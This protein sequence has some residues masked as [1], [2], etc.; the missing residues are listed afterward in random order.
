MESLDREQALEVLETAPV[1]HL[2]MIHEGE[3]YVTPM[4]FVVS[5]GRVLFRTMAG[6]KL[7][8]LRENPVVCIEISR[9]DEETGEWKS[10]IVKG[11]AEEVEEDELKQTT[12]AML[13]R[14]YEKVMGSP[15]SSGGVQPLAGLPHFIMVEIDEVTGMTSG[16]G[17]SARTR[18]G[19]L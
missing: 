1:A 11:R 6:R 17:L 13:L 9:F 16:A 15:L 4:S 14:K 2:G 19:R 18:P 3:P 5:G 10:A 7:E 8:A 12:I